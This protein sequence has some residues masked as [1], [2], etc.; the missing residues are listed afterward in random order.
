MKSNTLN[1]VTNPV[2]PQDVATKEY[3]DKR[4]HIIAVHARYCGI[5]RN[6]EY[7]F[8]FGG[9]N[10]KNCEE[11]IEGYE[12]FKGSTTGFIMPQ[13]GYIKR[14]RLGIADFNKII[15]KFGEDKLKSL[16]S[17][18]KLQIEIE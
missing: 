10:N 8:K 12:D 9:N 3:V 18:L 1:N 13:S 4:T 2:N 6:G 17:L 16:K 14:I 11:I 15:K 7:Q 5:L